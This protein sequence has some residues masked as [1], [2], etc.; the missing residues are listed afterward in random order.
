MKRQLQGE[1][2]AGR[3]VA[4]K[5]RQLM[6]AR[7]DLLYSYL[8]SRNPSVRGAIIRAF[9]ALPEVARRIRPS[10]ESLLEYESD[11]NVRGDL[12]QFIANVS[13]ADS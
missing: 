4:A 13:T 1:I 6:V 8:R 9:G 10:L 5:I 7:I 12:A 11:Q 2:E 3:Q